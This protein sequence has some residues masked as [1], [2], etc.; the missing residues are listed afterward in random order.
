M[1][2]ILSGD[3]ECGPGQAPPQEQCFTSQGQDLSGGGQD[4]LP[5]TFTEKVMLEPFFTFLEVNFSKNRGG[6]SCCF[7]SGETQEGAGDKCRA[8]ALCGGWTL[9]LLP[10]PGPHPPEWLSLQPVPSVPPSLHPMG[11]P[12]PPSLSLLPSLCPSGLGSPA[13][14]FSSGSL[15]PERGR[16]VRPEV[17]QCV[18]CGSGGLL[19]G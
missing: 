15:G 9:P 13:A 19:K 12:P 5:S 16:E 6:T 10:G 17:G 1:P 3:P 8:T 11:I 4:A 7:T 18:L 2:L 14:S